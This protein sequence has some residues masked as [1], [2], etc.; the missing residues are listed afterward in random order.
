MNRS[1]IKNSLDA[2]EKDFEKYK[3]FK[4]DSDYESVSKN[5]MDMEPKVRY[6]G[7]PSMSQPCY[8]KSWNDKANIFKLSD[9]I[10]GNSLFGNNIYV[11][12]MGGAPTIERI[13]SDKRPANIYSSYNPS[14]SLG[15]VQ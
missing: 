9:M 1:L 7:K 10:S 13:K 5:L 11:S 6:T 15:G 2:N 14:I 8:S 12:P 3:Y 4:N